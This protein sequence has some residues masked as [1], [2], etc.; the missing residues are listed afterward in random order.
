MSVTQPAGPA[1]ARRSFS[2]RNVLLALTP[3]LLG[4]AFYA[5]WYYQSQY[6]RQPLNYPRLLRSQIVNPTKLD[7]AYADADADLV[8]D[9]PADKGQ[10]LDPA[11]LVF[12]TLGPDP[13]REKEDWKD[14]VAHLA[15]ATGRK[16]AWA[17]P[18]E[19]GPG[20]VADLKAGALHVAGFSTGTVPA[21]VNDAGF[22]PCAMMADR[23]GKFGYEM[24]LLIPAGSD[25]RGPADLRGN[26]L[27][28]TRFNSLSS[29]KAPVV[30][31]WKAHG[32]VPGRDY[33][34][35]HGGSQELLIQGVANKQFHAVAV[36]NDLLKRV[37]ARGDADDKAFRSIYKS[38]TYPP[39][40]FGH[41]HRLAPPLAKAVRDAFQSFDWSGT[42]LA[43]AYASANQA[44]FV[45]VDYKEHWRAVRA[46]DAELARF[47]EA[48]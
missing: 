31:L 46:V 43:K 33:T 14:F 9:P 48:Q 6:P 11:E 4:L 24:E 13:D 42:S 17:A 20:A 23:D 10:L 47:A 21:V 28:V 2:I 19:S 37:V 36:A 22:V 29:F 1:P 30:L 45:P 3:A 5:G 16:V 41:T 8:A 34:Y 18:T 39:A 7:E 44:R 26:D 38:E 15:K 27:G 12:A 32:M 35:V 40:C 25:L